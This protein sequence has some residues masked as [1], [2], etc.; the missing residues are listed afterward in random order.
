AKKHG[1]TDKEKD[2]AHYVLGDRNS[3][4]PITTNPPAA[5][6]VR[7]RLEKF[8]Q[9]IADGKLPDKLAPEGRHLLRQ[10]PRLKSQQ[11]LR[12]AYQQVI[13][14]KL[15]VASFE[16]KRKEIEKGNKLDREVAEKFARS[17]L[18]GAELLT[19]GFVREV[20]RGDLVANALR[21]LYRRV[22]ERLPSELAER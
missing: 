12:K 19:A 21:G 2:Q 11:S 3:L 5:A 20:K 16:E 7:Q 22:N 1:T 18:G 4:T 6:Q 10:M 14:G 17:V 15:T 9:L 13:D 8:N